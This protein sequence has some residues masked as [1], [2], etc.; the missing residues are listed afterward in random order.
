VDERPFRE[1]YAAMTVYEDDEC[2]TNDNLID[3]KDG[4]VR[5]LT[6]F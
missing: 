3:L 5:N 6:F 4:T 1:G 2:A